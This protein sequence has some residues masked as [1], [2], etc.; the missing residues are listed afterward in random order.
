MAQ[1]LHLLPG[2]APW[3]SWC[4][5][6]PS[7]LI[8]DHSVD[9]VSSSGVQQG[10]PL[11]P[12]YFCLAL[13]PLVDEI[14]RLGPSYNKWYMD[15]GAIVGPPEVLHQVWAIL[16]SK[17]PALGLHLNPAKCEWSWL[18]PSSPEPSPIVG[19]PLSPLDSVSILGVPLGPPP[20]CSSFVGEG[21]LGAFSTV[22]ARLIDFE[23]SQSALFLLRVSFSSVRATHFMRSLTGPGWRLPS[24]R[25]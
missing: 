18:D 10:D 13:A 3:T 15:D 4:Y 23:D 12:L 1:V 17:G 19:V 9:I 25:S 22:V 24:T 16:K 21:L 2:L 5:R 11:G 8:Y 6:S 20:V 7:S 14:E